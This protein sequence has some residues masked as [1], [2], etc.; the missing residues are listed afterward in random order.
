MGHGIGYD[1]NS[2]SIYSPTL[3]SPLEIPTFDVVCFDPEALYP[4]DSYFPDFIDQVTHDLGVPN[5]CG[6]FSYSV[7]LSGLQISVFEIDQTSG[8]NKFKI[9]CDNLNLFGEV[10]ATLKG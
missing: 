4:L 6:G 2:N 9:Y 7:V 8:C 1:C 10:S 3:S 5:A